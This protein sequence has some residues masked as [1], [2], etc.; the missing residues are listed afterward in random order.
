[1]N[2]S[3]T[4]LVA[5]ALAMMPFAHGHASDLQPREFG[6]M[7]VDHDKTSVST[8]KDLD[9]LD[10]LKRKFGEEFLYVREGED[11]YVIRDPALMKRAWDA[12][13]PVHEAGAK[14]GRVARAQAIESLSGWGDDADQVRRARKIEKQSRKIDRAEARGESKQEIEREREELKRATGNRSGDRAT[15]DHAKDYEARQRDADEGLDR[16]IKNMKREIRDI[17]HEAQSRHTAE[18]VD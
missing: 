11:R 17:L 7:I 4:I 8:M 13:R 3:K 16:A 6:W 15:V 12:G 5:F 1:M 10:G 9:G 18:R 2:D 14:V